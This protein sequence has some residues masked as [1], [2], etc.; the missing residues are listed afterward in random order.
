MSNLSEGDR[1]ISK[2]TTSNLN[3]KRSRTSLSPEQMASKKLQQ[4]VNYGEEEFFI[5]M[6]NLL[7]SK[8]ATL[9]EQHI[10]RI[11]GK[12]DTLISENNNL[13]KEILSLKEENKVIKNNLQVLLRKSKAKTLIIGGLGGVKEGN[14]LNSVQEFFS[15]VLGVSDI[16]ID[17]V[18][19]IR[20][21]KLVVVELLKVSDVQ[22]ILRN[23]NKLKGTGIWINKDL[24]Y[25]DRQIKKK[26][27]EYKR[28]ILEKEKE[29][30]CYYVII[31]LFLR[32]EN[33]FGMKRRVW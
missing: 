21:G 6:S 15:K 11:E 17:R 29:A 18:F 30:K 8:M 13:N 20:E 14:Y 24:S 23:V 10:V 31:I 33:T 22:Q 5:K 3:R 1:D 9:V 12:I 28:K 26:L 7:D 32:I 4:E 19:S 2:Q 16:M 25:Q 27:V